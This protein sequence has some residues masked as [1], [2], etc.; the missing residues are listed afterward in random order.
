[1]NLGGEVPGA[2]SLELQGLGRKKAHGEG[3]EGT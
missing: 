3:D 2:G 1:M